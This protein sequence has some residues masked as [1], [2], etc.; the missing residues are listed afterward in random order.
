MK[1]L[2]D[3]LGSEVM[4]AFVVLAIYLVAMGLVFLL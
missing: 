1:L 2:A 4:L 3:E